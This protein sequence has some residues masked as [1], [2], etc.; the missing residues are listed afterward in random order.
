M[1]VYL[2]DIDICTKA[3]KPLPAQV[4]LPVLL[5]NVSATVIAESQ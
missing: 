4:E 1:T 3:D 2:N 5:G